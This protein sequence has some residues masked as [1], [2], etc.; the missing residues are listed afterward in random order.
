MELCGGGCCSPIYAGGGGCCSPIYAGSPASTK[1][2]VK[3]KPKGAR[4]PVKRRPTRWP[5][6]TFSSRALACLG[7]PG[8]LPP[9]G[10]QSALAIRIESDRNRTKTSRSLSSPGGGS[11]SGGGGQLHPTPKV[12]RSAP[13]PPARPVSHSSRRIAVGSPGAV[14]LLLSYRSPPRG[15]RLYPASICLLG[16][17]RLISS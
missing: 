5:R 12:S 11:G 17:F 9:S 7:L 16:S 6:R 2:L 15:G 3:C 1:V 8:R 14:R 13:P 10:H 4:V